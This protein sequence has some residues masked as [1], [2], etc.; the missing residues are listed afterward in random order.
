[1]LVVSHT[2]PISSRLQIGRGELLRDLFQTVCIPPAVHSELIRFH[3]R[4]PAFI[5]V[6]DVLNRSQVS[7]LQASLD[8]GEAEAIVLA[9]ETKADHLLMDERRG[10]AAA[11][12]AGV[13]VI[14]LLGVLLLARRRALIPSLKDCILELQTKAGFYLSDALIEKALAAAG[15]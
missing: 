3:L 15:E 2:S 8:L 1:M 7:L 11:T 5:E 10:R 14:G 13:Q 6:R 9:V 12:A 4:I